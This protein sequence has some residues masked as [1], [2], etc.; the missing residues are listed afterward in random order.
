MELPSY[1]AAGTVA[2]DT[3]DSVI[4]KIVNFGNNEEPVALSLDCDVEPDYTVALL[5]GNATDE[6]SMESPEN[7][8]DILL[9]ASGASRSFT[10]TVPA[11]SVSIL[12]LRKA[13]K[14]QHP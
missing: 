7:I 8:H 14:Q 4:V 6:N 2:T 9:R 10:H 5:T 13:G 12:T 1:P 3:D 11:L